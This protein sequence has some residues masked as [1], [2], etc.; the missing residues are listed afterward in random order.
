MTAAP[1]TSVAQAGDWQCVNP[2]C[3]NHS[4]YPENFVYGSK[5]NC[6]KCGTGKTAHRA[7]DWCCP[8]QQCVNH[9]NTVYG[10]KP[11]CSKCGMARPAKNAKGVNANAAPPPPPSIPS[12]RPGDWHCPN[13]S[14]KNHSAN[15]VF[16]NKSA[17]PFCG[18]AKPAALAAVGAAAVQVP[19][20]PPPQISFQTIQP[21]QFHPVFAQYMPTAAPEL[22]TPKSTGSAAG[23][24]TYGGNKQK[25][26]GDWH[27]SNPE[28]KNHTE[29]FVY[30]NKTS[31]PLCQ[32]PK[33]EDGQINLDPSQMVHFAT[34]DQV[35]AP[36]TWPGT[37]N[38]SQFVQAIPS[39]QD[40]KRGDWHCPN[41]LCK[42]HTH[43]FV[44]GSKSRCPICGTAK[45][46]QNDGTCFERPDDWQ[47]PNTACK[48]HINGVYGSKPQCGMCGTANPAVR[49]R[50]R[51]PR[52]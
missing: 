43:N 2:E 47:C 38:P 13:S 1:A 8:N 37:V 25:R 46:E 3:I 21:M 18:T 11:N 12:S 4:K 41:Q 28:C 31:C 22:R 45:A 51:S 15:V 48:N 50:S 34:V 30:A 36:A 24:G 35:Q 10:S 17:C 27:C 9:T 42:N 29:N 7:G 23:G 5:V 26:P 39:P 20:P 19:R 14:C 49:G 40:R 44:Y 32:S 52:H 16:A 6:P 33:P